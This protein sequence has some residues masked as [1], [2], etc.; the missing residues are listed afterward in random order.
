MHLS[1]DHGPTTD[2]PCCVILAAG[3]GRRLSM[4]GK[5]PKPTNEILGLSLGER[6][7]LA[8]MAAG[9]N[10]FIIVLGSQAEAVRAHFAQVSARRGCAVEFVVAADWELGNG[11]S[12]LAARDS[13]SNN[14][15]LLVMADHL[16]SA[17]LIREVL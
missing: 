7:V 4:L 17:G 16:V 9:V 1:N 5:G 12:V 13:I 8:C 2:V 6:T 10:R 15:F 11:M 3:A 14:R